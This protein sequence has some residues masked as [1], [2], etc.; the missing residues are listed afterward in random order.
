MKSTGMFGGSGPSPP[1][2]HDHQDFCQVTIIPPGFPSNYRQ[3]R[4][5]PLKNGLAKLDLPGLTWQSF[6]GEAGF[7]C[8]RH[9]PGRK[10]GHQELV[11]AGS[12]FWLQGFQLGASDFESNF[13]NKQDNMQGNNN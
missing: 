4:A 8:G 10:A 7:S 13:F 6:P 3:L 9:D 11:Q 5:K 2:W 1:T 12:R